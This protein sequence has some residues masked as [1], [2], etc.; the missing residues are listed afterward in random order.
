MKFA[1]FN[2]N[3]SEHYGVVTE[4][5]IKAVK[6]DIFAGWEFTEDTFSLDEVEL[7][8]PVLPSKVIGIGA[9]Y[10]GRREDLPESVPDLPVFF[11]KPD[12]S[13]IGPEKEVIIPH[14]IDEIK[15]ESELAVVIGKEASNLSKDEVLDHVFGYTIGNDITAPQFFHDDGHWTVGKSFDTFT[16]LGPVIET[17]LD[18]LK[19]NVKADIN[20]VEKQNSSTEHMIVPL[21]EMVAYL[22]TV[23]TLNPGDVILTGSPLGAHLIKAGDV[24]ECKIDEIG[25]LKNT[26]VR[27]QSLINS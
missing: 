8:A 26:P 15:F 27:A 11:L 9:N 25:T 23:M 17:E 19:I 24:M 1:R 22:S 6:G 14:S 16:P 13:V 4:E 2:Y 7:L 10:V 3:H 12:S 18:P 21:K 5:G 20:G